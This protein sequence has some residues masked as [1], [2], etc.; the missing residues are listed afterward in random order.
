[1]QIAHRHQENT[2]QFWYS[3]TSYFTGPSLTFCSL[4][5]KAFN[6]LA[7]WSSIFSNPRS[8]NFNMSKDLPFM[9]RLYLVC[10]ECTSLVLFIPHYPQHYY[11]IHPHIKKFYARLYTE[12]V[13]GYSESNIFPFTLFHSRSKLARCLWLHTFWKYFVVRILLV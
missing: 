9:R 6:G 2:P 7:Q 11:R 3:H 12:I 1:M 8:Q 10:L 5:F 4:F 13:V